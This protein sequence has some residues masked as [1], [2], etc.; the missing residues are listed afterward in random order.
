MQSIQMNHK[1]QGFTLI[2]L[3]IVVAIIGILAAIAV[4]QYQNYIA[5]SQFA[6]APSLMSAAKTT[7]EQEYLT[8]GSAP[9]ASTAADF[10]NLGIQAQGEYGAITDISAGGDDSNPTITYTFG[11]D[12][13]G[14][15]GSVDVNASLNSATVKYERG[16][17]G[18]WQC[19]IGNSGDADS[20]DAVTEFA[21]EAC[22]ST[23]FDDGS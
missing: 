13:G 7:I 16:A 15:S 23:S 6:E 20:K 1:Q 9:A 4:P 5:S 2:E 11:S 14:N 12:L 3:M 21:T 19:Y 22:S 8:T 18:D 17:N 10:E